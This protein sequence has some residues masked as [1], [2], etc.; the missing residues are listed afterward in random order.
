MARIYRW[1]I[2]RAWI[3]LEGSEGEEISYTVKLEFT[4]TNNQAE[5]EVLITGLELAKAVKA[6][7]VKIRT[8]SQLVANH[9]NE[10][11]Q[12]RAGKMEQYLK[13]VKQIIG[14]FKAG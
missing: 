7:R 12:P 3:V 8:D 10:R 2:R 4:A 9:V 6:N 11:F 5:Y 14:K 13:K 1:V